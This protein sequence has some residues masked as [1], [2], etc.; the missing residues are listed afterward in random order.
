MLRLP[1]TSIS[2]SADD[3]SACLENLG[4]YHG[5]LKQGFK[6]HDICVWMKEKREAIQPAS[7]H[8]HDPDD[9]LPSTVDLILRAQTRDEEALSIRTTAPTPDNSQQHPSRRATTS[10]SRSDDEIANHDDPREQAASIDLQHA[11]KPQ[12]H[13]PRKSSLL[14]FSQMP[15]SESS[16]NSDKLSAQGLSLPIPL[17]ARTYRPRTDTYSCEQSE[18]YEQAN[19]VGVLSDL[20]ID[21]APSDSATEC[22]G[23]TM[24]MRPEAESFVPSQSATAMRSTHEASRSLAEMLPETPSHTSVVEDDIHTAQSRDSPNI[25]LRR[26]NRRRAQWNS[27]PPAQSSDSELSLPPMPTTPKR[28]R[29][30]RAARTE[31]RSHQ[32][33]TFDGAFSVYDDSLPAVMQPRAPVD[34]AR[35]AILTDQYAAYTAP[36]GMGRSSAALLPIRLQSTTARLEPGEQSPTTRAMAMRGRRQRELARGARAEADRLER[37]RLRDRDR[38]ATGFDSNDEEGDGPGPALR[39]RTAWRDELEGDRV[40]EENWEGEVDLLA[41]TDVGGR[42]IRVLSGNARWQTWDFT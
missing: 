9:P 37:L 33:Q 8:Y 22:K 6:Q 23:V 4:T 11:S 3:V 5:L 27:S 26:S 32:R 15:S 39:T 41:G 17:P 1:P 28:I 31:S 29:I 35:H 20:H 13:A 16:S 19:I 38:I 7:Q 40:G 14:Q 25:T 18:E 10:D 34:L 12:R 2:L 36:P 21:S 30:N 42:G 24:A